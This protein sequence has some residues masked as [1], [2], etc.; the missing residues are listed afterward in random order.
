MR[1]SLDDEWEYDGLSSPGSIWGCLFLVMAVAA[2]LGLL[3]AVLWWWFAIGRE[4][5]YG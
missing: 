3:A 2:G 5:N 4:L 1:R